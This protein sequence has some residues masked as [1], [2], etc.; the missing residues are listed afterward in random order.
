ML[1]ETL[2]GGASDEEIPYATKGIG[3]PYTAL[4]RNLWPVIRIRKCFLLSAADFPGQIGMDPSRLARCE[5]EQREPA[6]LFINLVFGV[7]A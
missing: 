4:L 5:C 2:K 7:F 6:R 1:I 3:I